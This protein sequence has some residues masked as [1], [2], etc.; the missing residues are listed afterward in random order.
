MLGETILDPAKVESSQDQVA[1]LGLLPVF[2]VF[3][4]H[5]ETHQV[6]GTVT[7]DRGLLEDAAGLP[8]TGYEIHMG[9][10]ATEADLSEGVALLE[11]RTQPGVEIVDGVASTDGWVFGTYVHGLFLNDELRRRILA[12][13]ARRKGLSMGLGGDQAGFSQDAEYEARGARPGQPRHG[14]DLSG[15]EIRAVAGGILRLLGIDIPRS[16]RR[17][18]LSLPKEGIQMVAVTSRW[19]PTSV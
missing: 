18:V 12:N 3:D 13:L 6:T 4:E 17:P 2:T 9:A 8:F 15:H 11:R 10:T 5:K 7:T 1:G 16:R 19:L 14:E